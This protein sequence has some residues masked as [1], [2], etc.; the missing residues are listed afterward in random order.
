MKIL[1]VANA[2]WF[3][4]SHRLVLAK[5]AR[6]KRWEVTVAAAFDEKSRFI[7][8]NDITFANWKV[9]RGRA[10]ILSEIR[11]LLEL[12]KIMIKESPDLIHLIGIKAILFGGILGKI[13]FRDSGIVF[14]VSG[15]GIISTKSDWYV[16]LIN[17]VSNTIFKFIF[18]G[19]KYKVIVQNTNDKQFFISNKYCKKENLELIKGSGVDISEFYYSEEPTPPAIPVVLLASRMLW[20][21]GVQIFVDACIELNR[22]GV[23]AEYKIAG[24]YDPDSPDHIPLKV[25]NDWSKLQNIRWLGHIENMPKLISESNILCLPTM[26]GEGVPK[27]ILEGLASGRPVVTTDWP[28][29]NEVVLDGETGLLVKPNSVQSLV[30]A[31]AY[32]LENK[33]ERIRMGRY[34]RKEAIEKYSTET[35]VTETFKVYEDLLARSGNFVK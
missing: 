20:S 28:G 9:S 30:E 15:R 27:V 13:Y 25:L 6:N 3:F 14:A 16:K 33:D 10:S 32:L 29:C 4:V 19:D 12:R 7:T 34:A 1:Y 22:L 2:S 11:S 35:V 8:E 5:Y 24:K 23:H 31:I 21:K 17:I 26:Y 18:Y